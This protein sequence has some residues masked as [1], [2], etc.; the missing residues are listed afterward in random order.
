MIE[1]DDVA[2]GTF[3]GDVVV[4]SCTPWHAVKVIEGGTT[5]T[6]VDMT[7]II[8]VL[9]AAWLGESNTPHNLWREGGWVGEG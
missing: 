8:I 1:I 7:V 3:H 2:V 4:G 6:A 5:S 9:R